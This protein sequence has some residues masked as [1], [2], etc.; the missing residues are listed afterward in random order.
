MNH[1]R[2]S[3]PTPAMAALKPINFGTAASVACIYQL[4]C[5]VSAISAPEKMMNLEYDPVAMG[6]FLPQ[7]V[8]KG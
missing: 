3:A 4:V 8:G 6:A 2:I 5:A 1:A 7:R